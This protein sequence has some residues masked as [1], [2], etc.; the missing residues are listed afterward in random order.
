M[1]VSS[2]VLNE[3]YGKSSS[4]AIL[5]LVPEQDE[6]IPANQ[7]ITHT[8]RSN[9]AQETSPVYK[10]HIRIL[11]GSED[12][13]AVLKWHTQV[14]KILTGLHVTTYGPAVAIV[15]TLMDSTPRSL[16]DEGLAAAAQLRMERRVMAEDD[17]DAADAIHGDLGTIQQNDVVSSC[18]IYVLCVLYKVVKVVLSMLFTCVLIAFGFPKQSPDSLVHPQNDPP[19][20]S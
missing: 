5:P 4:K 9:P 10:V 6:E 20:I 18:L 2:S 7:M 13:R 3:N 14:N 1:K 12:C 19:L 11:Q 16:F 17:N 8:L 15:H